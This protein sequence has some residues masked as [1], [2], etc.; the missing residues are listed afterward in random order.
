MKRKIK[1]IVFFFEMRSFGVCEWFARKL[2]IQSDKIRLL[3][4][5]ISF[6]TFGSPLIIYAIMA[7]GLEHKHYFKFQL[8]KPKTS[9]W[10][11]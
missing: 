1:Q 7:W 11:L 9:I 8:R 2:G 4:I 5:Y 3:V 6:L 10:E